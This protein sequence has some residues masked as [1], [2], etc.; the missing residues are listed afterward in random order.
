MMGTEQRGLPKKSQLR[1]VEKPGEDTLWLRPAILQL[2]I[3]SPD[4]LQPYQTVTFAEIAATMTVV[5]E[6]T[7]PANGAT[8]ARLSDRGRT[9]DYLNYSQQDIVKNQSDISKLF[10]DWAVAL[11][12]TL[13]SNPTDSFIAGKE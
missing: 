12:N 7:A 8:L 9:R 4:N 10:F 3:S 11:G 5:F 2:N 13:N 1:I 6:V